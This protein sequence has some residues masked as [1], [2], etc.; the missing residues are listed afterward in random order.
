MTAP[1]EDCQTSTVDGAAAFEAARA[2]EY[3]EHAE[4]GWDDDEADEPEGYC[5]CGDVLYCPECGR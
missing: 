5:H 4:A 1:Q 3:D 2:E